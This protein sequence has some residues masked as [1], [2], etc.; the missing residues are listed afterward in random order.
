MK[1]RNPNHLPVLELASQCCLLQCPASPPERRE[2]GA[3]APSDSEHSITLHT[4]SSTPSSLPS[5]SPIA[6]I[7]SPPGLVGASVVGAGWRGQDWD[8]QG[9]ARWIQPAAST[10]PR[11]FLSLSLS[12]THLFLPALIKVQRVKVSTVTL[13]CPCTS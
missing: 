7:S 1:T 9:T 6:T 3:L 8:Q 12:E 4:R 13:P 5:P 10:S 11:S 2:G